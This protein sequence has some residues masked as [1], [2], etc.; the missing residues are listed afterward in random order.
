M[1]VPPIMMAPTPAVMPTRR[2]V[3]DA[4][5]PIM[6]PRCGVIDAAVGP[7]PAMMVAAIPAIV[8]A[9]GLVITEVVTLAALP[10]V[11]STLGIIGEDARVVEHL[12]G[13]R[14]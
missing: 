7:I 14:C 1:L 8:P 13:L 11:L 9:W 10:P 2:G 6:P 4:M 3:I 12:G 5:G